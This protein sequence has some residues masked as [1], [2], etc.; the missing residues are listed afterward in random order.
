[1]LHFN[2]RQW[3]EFR[4]DA[5]D[6]LSQIWGVSPDSIYVLHDA[7]FKSDVIVIK[8]G[9]GQLLHF[10]SKGWSFVPGPRC[11]EAPTLSGVWGSSDNN[12]FIVGRNGAIFHYDGKSWTRMVES[13][14]PVRFGPWHGALSE[15]T[16][17]GIKGWP[18]ELHAIWGSSRN[19]VYAVG[20]NAIVHYNGI[21][22]SVADEI[23]GDGQSLNLVAISGT[24]ASN[25]FAVGS[26]GAVRRDKKKWTLLPPLSYASDGSTTFKGVWTG[27]DS[28]AFFAGQAGGIYYFDGAEWNRMDSGAT[29]SLNG[30]WGS[31][32]TSVWAVGNH[33]T[34]LHYTCRGK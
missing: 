21:Q 34:I 29:E 30:I 6:G 23:R 2:G 1:M 15:R 26:G 31:S 28:K 13:N 24:S 18:E 11:G 9:M 10:G 5:V 3:T 19:N 25:I 20:R 17:N 12:V 4:T 16:S 32:P 8:P 14:R 7:C 22:W 27:E 33:G